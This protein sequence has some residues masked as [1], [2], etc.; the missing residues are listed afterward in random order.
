MDQEQDNDGCAKRRRLDELFAD[1]PHLSTTMKA[2]LLHERLNA[3]EPHDQTDTPELPNEAYVRDVGARGARITPE[4]AK[5]IKPTPADSEPMSLQ[6]AARLLQNPMLSKF[7]DPWT[8][9]RLH[10]LREQVLSSWS[11]PL[12]D[13]DTQ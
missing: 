11:I 8:K 3:R 10:A 7:A 1:M 6:E 4:S 13:P 5:G 2:R 12:P 9:E